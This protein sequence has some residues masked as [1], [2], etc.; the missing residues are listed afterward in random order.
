MPR[1]YWAKFTAAHEVFVGHLSV[2]LCGCRGQIKI[3]RWLIL[4]YC[5]AHF[6]VNE[7]CVWEEKGEKFL[8]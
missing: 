3:M 4:R 6:T 5:A 2:N 1:K 7:K 8:G